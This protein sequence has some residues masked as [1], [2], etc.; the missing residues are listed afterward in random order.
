MRRRD[1]DYKKD[2]NINHRMN[3]DGRYRGGDY[4]KKERY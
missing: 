3:D 1:R 2:K 4:K